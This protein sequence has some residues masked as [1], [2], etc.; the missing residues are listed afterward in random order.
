MDAGTTGVTAVLYD[1]DLRLLARAYREFDQSFPRPGWVEHDDRAILA[2]VDEVLAEVLGRPEASDVVAIGVANQRE[3]VFALDRAS[4]VAL[5]PGIVWQDRRTAERCDEL[6]DEDRGPLV[7]ART[8]LVID[9]YFSATKIEW[10]LREDANLRARAEGGEV[11]FCTVDTLVVRHLTGGDVCA[12]DPTNASRT[13]LFDIERRAWDAELCGLFGVDPAWLPEVRSSAGDFGVTAVEVAGRAIP[14]RGVAGDQQAALFGQGCFDVGSFKTTYGTGCFLLLN[15]GDRRVDSERGLL[16]TLAAS[17]DGSPSVAVEG[18]VFVGGALVQWL[19]DQMG[20]FATS[21][22]IEP[23]A[24]SVEDSGGVIVVPAFVGLGAP[25]WDA[26][27]RGAILGLTRG[28][29]RAHVAR[30]ALE[31]IALQNAELIEILRAESGLG[32][33]V[34]L[35]DGGAAQNDLLMQLQAD[36]AG[37]RVLRPSCVEATARGVAALAGLGLGLWSDPAAAAGFEE[38]RT[39]FAPALSAEERAERLGSWRAA[40]GRVLTR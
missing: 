32:L 37:A 10:M 2:A 18:S 39:E 12:T 31:A 29:S 8:G 14:I 4:G 5:R 30:A 21:P 16:T 36:F 1:A 15:T 11:V 35:A 19:R 9:P 38:E 17:R 24:R 6:R 40:V 28:S 3:T 33:E 22:E 7:R 25:Y 20:F 23:L 34:L 13:M 26:E 27:A